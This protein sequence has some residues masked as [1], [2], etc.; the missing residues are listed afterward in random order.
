MKIE[1]PRDFLDEWYFTRSIGHDP[2]ASY[3]PY[4]SSSLAF[5]G[6]EFFSALDARGEYSHCKGHTV[7]VR[8]W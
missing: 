7:L 2:A 5:D 1:V 3:R 4:T 6:K 8:P